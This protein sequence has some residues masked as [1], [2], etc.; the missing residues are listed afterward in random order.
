M[1]LILSGTDGLSDVD[2]SAATPAVDLLKTAMNNLIVE[3]KTY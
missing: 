2:G 1:S 3:I